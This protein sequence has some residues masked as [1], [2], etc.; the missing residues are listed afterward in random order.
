MS[1]AAMVA[2]GFYGH[3][4]KKS[5]DLAPET[6]LSVTGGGKDNGHTF[7]VFVT[8]TAVGVLLNVYI[9]TQ[10]QTQI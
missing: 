2:A 3:F 1:M 4:K 6:V 8:A 10:L 9:Q 7:S 5:I